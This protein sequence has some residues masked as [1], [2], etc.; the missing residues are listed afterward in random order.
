MVLGEQVLNDY[1]ER[2]ETGK[3]NIREGR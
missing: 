1:R 2:A 3:E